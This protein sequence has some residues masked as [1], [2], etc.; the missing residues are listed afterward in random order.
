MTPQNHVHDHYVQFYESEQFLCEAV[1][2][3]VHEGLS[4]DAP[5]VL[6]ATEPHVAAIRSR[7]ISAGHDFD[8]MVRDGDIVCLDAEHILDTFMVDG[9][10]DEHLFSRQVGPILDQILRGRG[11]QQIYA[12]GEMVDLLWQQGNEAAAHAL[13]EIWNRL[14][15]NYNFVLLC[16]Y[17]MSNF[18]ELSDS[19]GLAAICRSH[20]HVVPAETYTPQA[21]SETRA[22]EIVMLQHR[23]R[24]LE[25]ELARLRMMQLQH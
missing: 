20:S 9:M 11:S 8:I 10:P 18:N 22:R 7:L 13:E 25:T 12:Y 3:F 14:R 24:A 2:R 5:V 6:V 17:A 21:P 15:T 1:C 23:V 16:G 4:N 19:A